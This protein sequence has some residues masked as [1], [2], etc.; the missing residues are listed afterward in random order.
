M[1]NFDVTGK[2]TNSGGGSLVP[3]GALMPYAG[4][5]APANWLLCNGSTFSQSDYPELYA[6]LG[7]NVL[8]D[9]SG[10]TIIGTSSSY[11]LKS[12]GGSKDAIIPLHN[13]AFS[14]NNMY[15][16]LHMR[17][18][19]NASTFG[20][21]TGVLDYYNNGSDIQWGNGFSYQSTNSKLDKIV[22]N[23]TPSGTISSSGESGTDK[24][25]NHTWL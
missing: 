22:F 10:R 25:C 19:N 23:G 11:V 7:S 15:G 13:H 24:T 12:T 8:P 9:L 21:Q 4:A 18:T 17:T 16:E 14:G 5:N 1:A 3:V 6:V 2:L 20:Y